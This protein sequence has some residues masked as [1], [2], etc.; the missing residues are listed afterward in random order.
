LLP[1]SKSMLALAG[2]KAAFMGHQ[3]VIHELLQVDDESARKMLEVQGPKNGKTILMDALWSDRPGL[4]DKYQVKP[5]DVPRYVKI[6][7]ML[8]DKSLQLGAELALE[9]HDGQSTKHMLE[10]LVQGHPQ[11]R[12][13][14]EKITAK[15]TFKEASPVSL[16][17]TD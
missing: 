4:P 6:A 15:P 16:L 2:H 7:D 9:S 11:F 17:M 5:E 13:V 10:Q 12:P 8:V 1:E 3:D 14:L